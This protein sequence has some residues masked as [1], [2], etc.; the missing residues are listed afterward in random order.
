MKDEM[1]FIEEVE[2]DEDII[3]IQDTSTVVMDTGRE[4]ELY[5]DDVISQQYAY[6]EESRSSLNKAHLSQIKF[7][8]EPPA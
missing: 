8:D 4:S 1:E 7:E 6:E 5:Y 3:K 2:K